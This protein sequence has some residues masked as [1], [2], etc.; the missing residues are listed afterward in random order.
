MKLI[1]SIFFVLGIALVYYFGSGAETEDQQAA[2]DLQIGQVQD[3][4]REKKPDSLSQY[5]A[6]IERPLFIEERQ[7]AAEEE[8]KVVIKPKPVIEDLKVQ[9][10]GIALSSEGILAV[11]KDLKNGKTL[12]MR[13]GDEIYGWALKGVSE[14]SFTFSKGG[15]E[16]V[17]TFKG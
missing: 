15:K 7:F 9:A 11:L 5:K 4:V 13:I 12:R 14:T 3:E 17:I 10:L 2:P 1:I 8:V 16:K 6:I